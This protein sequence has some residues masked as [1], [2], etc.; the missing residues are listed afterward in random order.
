MRL[1]RMAMLKRLYIT[2]N[3]LRRARSG[4]TAIEY[5]MIAALIVLVLVVSFI[6]IGTSVSSFFFEAGSAL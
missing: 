4:A 5:A 3:T 6:S 1:R 2:L